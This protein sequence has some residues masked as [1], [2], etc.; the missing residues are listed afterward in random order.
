MTSNNNV[1][2]Q[3]AYNIAK[4][5]AKDAIW[6]NNC[7]NWTGHQ[8]DYINGAAK[9]VTASFSAD[10]YHGLSGIATFLSKIVSKTQDPILTWTLEGCVNS[11]C[12]ILQK[13]TNLGNYGLYSGKLGAAYHLWKIGKAQN[14]AAWS[15]LAIKTVLALKNIPP[16]D[17]EID[18]I[19][20]AAG[21]I[22]ALLEMHQVE[23]EDAFLKMA[24]RCGDFLL[25]KA[26]KG[27][28]SW[29]WISIPNTQHGLTGY[30]H[31]A[32]GIA[33]ALLELGSYTQEQKYTHAASM[34]FNYEKEW[35]NPSLSN[36]ADLREYQPH[37][38]P[39]YSYVWCHG[40]PGI[41]LS[42]LRAFQLTQDEQHLSTARIAAETTYKNVQET[43][44][45]QQAN[46]SICHGIA[47][48][49]DIL[50]SA[51]SFFNEPKYRLLAEQAGQLGY[52][53]FDQTGLPWPSGVSDPQNPMNTQ[54]ETPG[55]ML[56][57]AGTGYFFLRLAFPNEMESQLIVNLNQKQAV[58]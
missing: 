31:G 55:L 27:Q 42:R 18:I 36:W 50:L 43:L 9:L 44:Q 8:V 34:G 5:L 22:P 32:A 46:F 57:L 30:S 1:F 26:I 4:Q 58:Y 47:G 38:A 54:T 40:A 29:S 39:S 56:G 15:E 10:P 28:Q 11:V 3:T 51:A 33:L 6:Y 25:D 19:S 20:G 2:F 53:N 24:K 52:T 45:G 21:A 35:F 16:A 13:E 12:I 17:H 14:R 48:N 49:A 41:A 7:C 23:A 37:S